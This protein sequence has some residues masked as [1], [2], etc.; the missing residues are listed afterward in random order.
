V[1]LALGLTGCASLGG[2][3]PLPPQAQFSDWNVDWTL[4]DGI[5]GSFPLENSALGFFLLAVLFILSLPSQKSLPQEGLLNPSSRDQAFLFNT[6]IT[7]F[8]ASL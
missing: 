8:T 7:S 3:I 5:F 2:Q 4:L 1:S 6:P